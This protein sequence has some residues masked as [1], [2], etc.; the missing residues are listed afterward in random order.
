M[1]RGSVGFVSLFAFFLESFAH[2]MLVGKLEPGGLFA[3]QLAWGG[4]RGCGC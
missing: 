3:G 2:R 1:G 4:G